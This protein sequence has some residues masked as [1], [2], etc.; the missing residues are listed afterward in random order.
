MHLFVS[1]FALKTF[2]V[3]RSISKILKST[4]SHEF[5]PGQ[6]N[7]RLISV[8]TLVRLK[9]AIQSCYCVFGIF[10]VFR[11]QQD[12]GSW[13]IARIVYSDKLDMTIT[14]PSCDFWRNL[15]EIW[16]KFSLGHGFT[17][18]IWQ[19]YIQQDP[20]IVN[21]RSVWLFHHIFILFQ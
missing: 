7:I 10:E 11:G 9:F 18:V 1:L 19:A 3:P 2:R 4:M 14:G 17:W 16:V 15:M 5:E 20:N 13:K 12:F 21:N 8:S 6:T